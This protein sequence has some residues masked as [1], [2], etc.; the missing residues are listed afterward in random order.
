MISEFAILPTQPRPALDSYADSLHDQSL[1][2]S[3]APSYVRIEHALSKLNKDPILNQYLGRPYRSCS[4]K[5]ETVIE[6]CSNLIRLQEGF[7]AIG[8][9][10]QHQ[11]K[12]CALIITFGLLTRQ[13]C[14][15]IT[16]VT[17]AR[18]SKYFRVVLLGQKSRFP[19]RPRRTIEAS[20]SVTLLIDIMLGDLVDSRSAEEAYI[21]MSKEDE[22][23]ESR[24]FGKAFWERV[25]SLAVRMPEVDDIA[26]Q[27]GL[28]CTVLKDAHVLCS[29]SMSDPEFLL[30]SQD[31]VFRST[32]IFQASLVTVSDYLINRAK[33]W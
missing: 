19:L 21:K 12:S 14:D 18:A 3:S 24:Q 1:R 30:W 25:G 16:S 29:H 27:V 11:G 17:F 22:M 5:G 15:T 33:G 31:V 6:I 26:T 32:L 7:S 28:M 2:R 13:V 20:E 23:W 10:A 9:L 8:S 4:K